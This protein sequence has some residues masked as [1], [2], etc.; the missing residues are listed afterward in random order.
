MAADSGRRT[1]R[2][3]ARKDAPPLRMC[4]LHELRFWQRTGPAIGTSAAYGIPVLTR[5][6]GSGRIDA[7]SGL[8]ETTQLILLKVLE[9]RMLF[10]LWSVCLILALWGCNQATPAAPV[11]SSNK[12]TPAGLSPASIQDSS[13]EVAEN[14]AMAGDAAARGHEPIEQQ[15][16]TQLAVEDRPIDSDKTPTPDNRGKPTTKAK[17]TVAQ[18]L[19]QLE[20]ASSRKEVQ[21]AGAA[22]ELALESDP[23]NVKGLLA[24]AEITKFLARRPAR[25][26]SGAANFHKSADY[27]RRAAKAKP[28]L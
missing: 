12:S 19:E 5:C 27:V 22:L 9:A 16:E 1:S 4:R 8:A 28:Q 2:T 18:A 23:K 11:S 15:P 13:P 10:R 3:F 14:S 17:L 24:A 6:G 20:D 7:R 26:E 25:G 21:Q